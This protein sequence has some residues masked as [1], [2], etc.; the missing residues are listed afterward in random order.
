MATVSMA[1]LDQS[2]RANLFAIPTCLTCPKQL[3]P[4]ANSAVCLAGSGCKAPMAICAAHHQ[5]VSQHAGVEVS[6]ASVPRL[7]E[8]EEPECTSRPSRGFGKLEKK[9]KS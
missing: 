7:A 6:V 1:T 5:V 8:D 9:N 3:R 4:W 2:D